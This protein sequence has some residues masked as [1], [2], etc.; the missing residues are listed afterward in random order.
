MSS[1]DRIDIRILGLVQD[2]AD[3]TLET[4]AARVSLSTSQC[5]RRLQQLR[6]HGYISH[7]TTVLDP[8]RLGLGL[9]A[10][11]MVVLRPQPE[12]PAAFYELVGRSSEVLEC[13]MITGDADYMLRICTRDL[14]SFSTFLQ[15]LAATNLVA[16][17][18]SSIVVEEKKC[19]T[20]LPVELSVQAPPGRH[21]PG[22]RDA[23]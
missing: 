14:H 22:G 1:L 13:S 5:S 16:S 3:L 7:V 12:G 17:T 9:K 8:K 19:T 10:Y 6:E 4:L 23:L 11:V 20:A 2:N 18:R 15:E 21:S